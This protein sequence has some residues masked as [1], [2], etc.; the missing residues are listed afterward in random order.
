MGLF[1]ARLS[2]GCKGFSDGN[3]QPLK[4][5][6]LVLHHAKTAVL[7]CAQPVSAHR[8]CKCVNVSTTASHCAGSSLEPGEG[9]DIVLLP[10]EIKREGKEEKAHRGK[11][12]SSRLFLGG[13][14]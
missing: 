3:L 9:E 12:W 5:A 2:T 8:F 11:V 10:D 4:D 13:V 1:R 7:C 14:E 6:F